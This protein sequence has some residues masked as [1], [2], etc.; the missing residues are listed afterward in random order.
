LPA[1]GSY[2]PTSQLAQLTSQPY[3][4][5]AKLIQ[6]VSYNLGADTS[7]MLFGLAA[8]GSTTVPGALAAEQAALTSQFG[9]ASTD[10]HFI[11][12]SGGGDTTATPHAVA[13]LLKGMTTRPAFTAYFDALPLLGVDGSLAFVTDFES[14]PTLAGAKGQ[15]HAKTGTY[16]SGPPL[17]LKGQSL[18]GYVDAKSGRRLIF[19]L[20]V[21]GVPINSIDDV[22]AVFQDEGTLSAML[23]KLL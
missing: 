11:D 21:N 12:G 1:Q 7:L 13:M 14:D 8:N 16:V 18:A 10:L 23:W 20:A 22:L 5:Y 3:G 19:M 9:I 6:K 2:A 15:V 4:D 17:T